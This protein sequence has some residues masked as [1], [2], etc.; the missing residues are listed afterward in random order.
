MA[1]L[2][3][4]PMGAQMAPVSCLGRIAVAL[5]PHDLENRV[6]TDESLSILDAMPEHFP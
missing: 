3:L 4:G 1:T 5:R 6:A 2:L